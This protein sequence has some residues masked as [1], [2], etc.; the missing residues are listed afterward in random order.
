MI[1]LG[2]LI[3]LD[4]IKNITD[5]DPSLIYLICHIGDSSKITLDSRIIS[6]IEDECRVLSNFAII[7]YEPP[8][9]RPTHEVSNITFTRFGKH[10]FDELQSYEICRELVE[11]LD[12][13]NKESFSRSFYQNFSF[14]IDPSDDITKEICDV[15]KIF[16]IADNHH[17]Y[18]NDGNHLAIEYEKINDEI[19]VK[20][21]IQCT[22]SNVVI[23]NITL[24]SLKQNLKSYWYDYHMKCDFCEKEFYVRPDLYSFKYIEQNSL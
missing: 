13:Q 12:F 23:E 22:C 18:D 7:N 16:P 5:K 1:Y 20:L 17:E 15:K 21:I 14:E 4:T 11:L 9:E 24:E 6:N 10:L 2:N 3:Y 19:I 8:S